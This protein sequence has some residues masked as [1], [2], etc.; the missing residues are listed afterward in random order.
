MAIKMKYLVHN[1]RLSLLQRAVFLAIE[2]LNLRPLIDYL[3]A[4]TKFRQHLVLLEIILQC[5]V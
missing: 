5:P 2:F 4:T 1:Y 3:N